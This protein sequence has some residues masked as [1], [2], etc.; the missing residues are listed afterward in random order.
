MRKLILTLAVTLSIITAQSQGKYVLVIHGGAGNVAAADMQPHEAKAYADKLYEAIKA[1]ELVLAAGGNA[2]DAV[3][4]SVKVLENSELFNAGKGAVYNYE[5]RHELD[6]SVM[7]G[8]TMMAGAVAGTTTIM[9]PVLAARMVMDSSQHVM[10]SGAGADAFAALHGLQ[11]VDNSYFN[12]SKGEKEYLRIKNSVPTEG[13]KGTVGAVALDVHGNLAAATSTGGMTYK[14]WGRIGDSPV[15]GAGTYANNQSC[16]VSCTGHGEYF[17]RNAVAYDL[18]ARMLYLGESL[19]TAASY[20]IN[21]KLKSQGG[22]GGLI[23]VDKNGNI[24]MPYNTKGMLR[25]FVVEGSKPEVVVG[26]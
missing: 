4:E 10:L 6:A 7:D 15:I 5:G 9:N 12:S 19:N 17:I 23:A 20:I 16:A 2:I 24:A 18:S 1:G 3:I 11:Q 13:R 21:N 26:K 25:G 8:N 22:T 14:R